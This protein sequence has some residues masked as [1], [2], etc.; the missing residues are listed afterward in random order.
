MDNATCSEDGFCSMDQE[1][2]DNDTVGD[3][4]D[5]CPDVYNPGQADSD[6]D[7]I[8]D[9]CDICGDVYPRESEPE[10]PT[11]GDGVVDIFDL[12]EEIDFALGKEVPSACQLPRADVPTGTPPNCTDPDTDVDIFDILVIINMALGKPNCCDYYYFGEI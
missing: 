12:L 6:G 8:G 11:C 10:I 7:G 9:V 2:A 4:C 1:D 5:N 3:V